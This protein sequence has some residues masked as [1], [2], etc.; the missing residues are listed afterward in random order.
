MGFF[1]D[2][3]GGGAK[4]GVA[5]D[6]AKLALA[7]RAAAGSAAAPP[8]KKSSDDEGSKLSPAYIG[9]AAFLTLP[10]AYMAFEYF[11]KYG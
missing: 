3:V 11:S 2:A 6:P 9:K 1:R 7:R 8:T 4:T 10:F 5:G